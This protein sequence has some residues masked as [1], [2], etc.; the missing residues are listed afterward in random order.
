M[1]RFNTSFCG[2]PYTPQLY[3]TLMNDT[4]GSDQTSSQ[5]YPICQHLGLEAR[6]QFG[7]ELLYMIKG[8]LKSHS[9]KHPDAFVGIPTIVHAVFNWDPHGN[10]YAGISPSL[11]RY[12]PRDNG[13]IVPHMVAMPNAELVKAT[14]S[15]RRQYNISKGSLVVCRHGGDDSFNIQYVK[16]GIMQLV[17]KYNTSKLHFLFLD[18]NSFRFEFETW[19]KNTTNSD[20]FLAAAKYQLHFL[21]GTTDANIKERYFK[22]CDCMLHARQSGE[23]FGL[24]VAEMSIRNKPIITQR[25]K[26]HYSDAHIKILG[27]KGFYYSNQEEVVKIVSSFVDNGVPVDD[28]NQYAEF[29]PEKVMEKFKKLLLEPAIPLIGRENLSTLTTVW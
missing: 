15:F 4:F 25:G 14:K 12:R 9:P 22:T 21:P 17:E 19:A 13:N 1:T 23:T 16:W 26:R 10:V 27:G 3:A 8:G 28:Y 6:N 29:T 2:D 20:Y 18:T 24:A 11:K 7:C 5:T